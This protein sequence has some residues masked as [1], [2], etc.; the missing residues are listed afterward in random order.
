MHVDRFWTISNGIY[1][2]RGTTSNS[3]SLDPIQFWI[4]QKLNVLFLFRGMILLASRVLSPW[5]KTWVSLCFHLSI[6]LFPLLVAG[7]TSQ[8]L[9]E[10]WTS[11][12]VRQVQDDP[13]T[14]E[15]L[16]TPA[17]VSAAPAQNK[18]GH[19]FSH[20]L[21]SCYFSSN[22][23]LC[24][25]CSLLPLGKAA[26]FLLARTEILSGFWDTDEK[27][28]TKLASGSVTACTRTDSSTAYYCLQ[29]QNK[30]PNLG[31]LLNRDSG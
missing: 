15:R 10:D 11:N 20:P 18:T 12:L 4:Q 13:T 22:T 8:L 25:S 28:M 31:L 21:S 26:L 17:P 16:L 30:L 19:K 1:L 3:L 27:P 23:E 9:A 29:S 7:S 14:T 24:I 6:V 5:G 2:H